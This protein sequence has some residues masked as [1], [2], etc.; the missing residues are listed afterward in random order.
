MRVASVLAAIALTLACT[1][2]Q[3]NG[4][5]QDR[6]MV[7]GTIWSQDGTA[8]SKALIQLHKLP[9]DTP[10]DVMANS[11]ELAKSDLDGRFVL[12]SADAER[13]YW[14]SIER[15]HGCEGL[16]LSELE[17]RRVPVTFHR[18]ERRDCE[19]TINV[20]VDNGCNLKL[21]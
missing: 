16:T 2:H 8:V 5:V 6:I 3:T 18:S 1:H 19:S 11:Y 17:A 15:S 9:K 14:L 20:V 21:Q 4:R 12:R 10:N 13:Q 7:C